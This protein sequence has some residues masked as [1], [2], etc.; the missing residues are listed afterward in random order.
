[1]VNFMVEN[2]EFFRHLA[3]QEMISQARHVIAFTGAGIS[4]GAGTLAALAATDGE[5]GSI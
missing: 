3:A 4:T 2:G 1:M 5:L